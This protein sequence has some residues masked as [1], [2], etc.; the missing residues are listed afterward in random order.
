MLPLG[1]AVHS[2]VSDGAPTDEQIWCS[3]MVTP[4]LHPLELWAETNRTTAGFE[5]MKVKPP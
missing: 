5:L 4:V 2:K 3:E 1:M